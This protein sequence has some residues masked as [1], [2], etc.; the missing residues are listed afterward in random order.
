MK[1]EMPSE[2]LEQLRFAYRIIN[3]RLFSG[4]LPG[5][6]I[7]FSTR[8]GSEGYFQSGALAGAPCIALDVIAV[9]VHQSSGKM[10][11]SLVH[12]ACHQYRQ[13]LGSPPR[14][15]YHDQIWSEKM[16]E[17]GLQ[18]SSTGLPGGLTTGQK[19]THF[20]LDDGPLCNLIRDLFDKGFRISLAAMGESGKGTQ[21]TATKRSWARTKYICSGCKQAVLGG[22]RVNVVCGDC[23]QPF[24]ADSRVVVHRSDD[25]KAFGAEVTVSPA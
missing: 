25:S 1:I 15:A 8:S 5:C 16:I 22:N 3:E 12:Q 24:V 7:R 13:H 19:M 11:E 9:G 21:V 2:P 10:I 20:L 6:E 18:P 23:Q 4:R 17:I 14:R